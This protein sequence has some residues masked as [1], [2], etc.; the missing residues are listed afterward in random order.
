MNR[1]VVLGTLG[2]F[3]TLN[4]VSAQTP[5]SLGIQTYAGLTI[6]GDTT[7]VYSIQYVTDVAQTNN[8]G[9]WKCLEFLQLPVS[10][11]LWIDK[12]VPST[13]KRFYRAVVS[14]PTNFVFIPS[15]TFRMG[16]PTNEIDRYSNEGPQVD[17]TISRGFW[18][19]KYEVSQGEY[20]AV[21][22]TNPSF[23]TG[24]LSRP[25][26]MVSRADATNYCWALTQR[27]RAAG[28]IPINCVYR[29]PWEAEWEYACRAWTSD[30]RF[31]Y[32]DD[33]GYT[34]LTD[35]AWYYDNSG[36]TTHPV[37]QKLP[38]PSG[39]YDMHGNVYEWCQDWAGQYPGGSAIDPHGEATGTRVSNGVARGGCW[40]FY[41]PPRPT[42]S[43]SRSALRFMV[44]VPDINRQNWIGF[45]VV[46]GPG[47]Q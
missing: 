32:G 17:V 26:E 20:M 37:G 12:S 13:S 15:G 19:A 29:L 31:S 23:F 36:S 4:S 45:R 24:D 9:T 35:Y 2:L 39:L 42:G 14:A 47:P 22:G 41:V 40:G 27:E 34:N 16:S 8:E 38:N 28:R 5:T 3:T 1:H 30:R 18:M 7:T 43:F 33:P 44:S 46:L 25:V 11:Y 10:P 6:T 21:M